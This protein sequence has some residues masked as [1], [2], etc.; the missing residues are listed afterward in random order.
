MTM[1]VD[2]CHDIFILSTIYNVLKK[3]ILNTM[4]GDS[5]TMQVD[6]CNDISILSNIYNVLKKIILVTMQGDSRYR[7]THTKYTPTLTTMQV[8]S[9]P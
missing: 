1:Q 2:S 8:E 4:Q 6:S 9:E 7:W 3:I 5:L